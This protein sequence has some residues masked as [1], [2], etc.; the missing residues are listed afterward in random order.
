V[1]RGERL[2]AAYC[3]PRAHRRSCTRWGHWAVWSGI[4]QAYGEALTTCACKGG[5]FGTRPRS[6][7][8]CM[9]PRVSRD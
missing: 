1:T 2:C 7:C 9:E 8:V 4:A 3:P 6:M 5:E